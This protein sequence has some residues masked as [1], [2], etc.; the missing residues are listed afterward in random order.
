MY[1]CKLQAHRGVSTDYPENTMPAFAGAVEQGYDIIELDPAVTLDGKIVVLHDASINR[2]GRTADGAVIQEPIKISDITYE[3]ALQYDFG[4][5]YSE[6]FR[7]VKLPLL[8]EA[9]AFA[10]KHDIPVKIDNKFQKFTKEQQESLFQVVKESGARIAFT[11]NSIEAVRLVLSKL[12]DVEIHYDGVV[13]KE[14]LEELSSIVEKG[15]LV[16]WL[17]YQCSLTTWV[18]IPFADQALSR[19]VKQYARLG[20]W[21][22]SEEEQRQDAVNNLGADIIETTGGIKPL[23]PGSR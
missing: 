9:L 10:A 19:L 5:W 23:M 14:I 11:C 3:E 13:T 1:D 21:I 8:S 4:L 15:K 6:E 2:T 16:V 12:A 17:P 7:G 20:I 18:K 22:L